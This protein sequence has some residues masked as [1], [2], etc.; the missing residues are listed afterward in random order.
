MRGLF[1]CYR[2]NA[3]VSQRP[4]VNSLKQRLSPAEQDRRN[5]NVQF[6]NEAFTKILLDCVRSTADAHVLSGSGLACAVQRLANA[7]GYEV[8]RRAA[9]HLDGRTRMMGQDEGWHVIRWVVSPPA[10]P[11]FVRPVATI[12]TEHV[13]SENPGPDILKT[14]GGEIIVNAGRTAVLTEHGPLEG[15]GWEYPLV[16]VPSARP[17][18][19]LMS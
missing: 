2:L 5:C 18:G 4:Q 19:L 12:R 11:V 17:S 3:F 7:S 10:F 16:Q 9:F 15:A 1:R 13:S 8:E 14:T 6:I